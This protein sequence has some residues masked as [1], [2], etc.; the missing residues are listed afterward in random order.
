MNKDF[1]SLINLIS[2]LVI[3]NSAYLLKSAAVSEEITSSN[4]NKKILE[5]IN[6][7]PIN[8]KL[9]EEYLKLKSQLEADEKI[10]FDLA[11]RD[12]RGLKLTNH[13]K[14]L[15]D[16]KIVALLLEYGGSFGGVM[17]DDDNIAKALDCFKYIFNLTNDNSNL[18]FNILTKRFEL[19]YEQLKKK[20]ITFLDLNRQD[21]IGM[22]P[23]M[24]AA[25]RGHEDFLIHLLQ[26]QPDSNGIID[27]LKKL[28]YSNE[29]FG[30]NL[31]MTNANNLTLLD[32]A[33]KHNR[34]KV[35]NFLTKP[36]YDKI[37]AILLD[38]T[39]LPEPL[40]Y[41]ICCYYK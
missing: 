37:S 20:K 24:W 19:I 27:K 15:E 40:A 34:M 3:F 12:L 11:F 23:L 22:T 32:L 17:S 8:E 6:N 29:H 41:I 10:F 16:L 25:A 7:R 36:I 13:S 28:V 31:D 35:I 4:I 18:I 21:H 30:L 2:L 38:S 14:F 5:V 1:C 33:R 39:T 26:Y 9:L